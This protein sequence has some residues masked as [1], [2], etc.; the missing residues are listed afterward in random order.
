MVITRTLA[1]F[2]S[3]RANRALFVSTVPA[4]LII[5]HHFPITGT[6]E[7]GRFSPAFEVL[8]EELSLMLLLGFK[9]LLAAF[10]SGSWC[11]VNAFRH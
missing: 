10:S 9:A 8:T 3:G 6:L 2:F 1:R 5:L 11:P 7:P 4:A